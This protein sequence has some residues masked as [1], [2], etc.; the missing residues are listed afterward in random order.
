MIQR[1]RL[2]LPFIG[3][4]KW[5]K[6]SVVCFIYPPSLIYSLKVLLSSTFFNLITESS[7]VFHFLCFVSCGETRQHYYVLY[8]FF[9]NVSEVYLLV[10][11]ISSVLFSGLFIPSYFHVDN[12]C[13]PKGKISIC[14]HQLPLS[15]TFMPKLNVKDTCLCWVSGPVQSW[16]LRAITCLGR[17]RWSSGELE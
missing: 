13:R 14:S 11:K 1:V 6:W 2:V 10:I 15:F 7:F 8:F 4:S 9:N 5:V 3:R 16:G 12:F 17:G